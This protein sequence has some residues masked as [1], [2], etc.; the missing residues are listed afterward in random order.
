MVVIAL[1]HPVAQPDMDWWDGYIGRTPGNRRLA[2]I[3]K[4]LKS[5]FRAV[6]CAESRNLPYQICRGGIFLKD[7]AAIA[8]LGVIGKNN[9]LVTP[10]YGPRIRLGAL[11]LDRSVDRAEPN[12]R[13]APCDGCDAPCQRA[14]PM[15]GFHG[16]SYQ[17]SRCMRQM[18]R[19][20][21]CKIEIGPPLYGVPARYGVAYCRRCELACPVG[22]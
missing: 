7:A 20:E 9:L 1:S 2:T 17:P 4:K 14:C 18:A 11:W 6:H 22:S 21:A 10:Q 5:W 8:G 15:E 3:A 19:D 12:D 13:F 16:G